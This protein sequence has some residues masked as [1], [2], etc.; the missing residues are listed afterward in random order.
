MDSL[1]LAIPLKKYST[2]CIMRFL[3]GFSFPLP[4]LFAILIFGGLLFSWLFFFLKKSS[5]TNLGG[6]G[7][8]LQLINLFEDWKAFLLVYQ[9]HSSWNISCYLP[10]SLPPPAS[11]LP[12]PGV[13]HRAIYDEYPNVRCWWLWDHDHDCLYGAYSMVCLSFSLFLILTN[14]P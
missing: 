10:C 1:H 9:L 2:A 3:V 11:F 12:G 8:R 13:V 6:W 4:T 7:Q 5:L 14:S